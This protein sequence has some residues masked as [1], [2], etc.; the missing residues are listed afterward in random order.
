MKLSSGSDLSWFSGNAFLFRERS[1]LVAVHNDNRFG[2]TPLIPVDCCFIATGLAP[3]VQR[4]LR[5]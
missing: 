3:V 2:S 4:L 5:Y 1:R